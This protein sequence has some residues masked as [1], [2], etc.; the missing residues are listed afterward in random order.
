MGG[1]SQRGR[2]GAW[3][4]FCRGS[5]AGDDLHFLAVFQKKLPQSLFFVRLLRHAMI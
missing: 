2:S 1:L 4:W 3:S 5:R